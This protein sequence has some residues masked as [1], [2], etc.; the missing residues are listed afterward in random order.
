MNLNNT[1]TVTQQRIALIKP[2]SSQL[3]LHPP[4]QLTYSNTQNLAAASCSEASTRG[5]ISQL[6]APAPNRGVGREEYQGGGFPGEEPKCRDYVTCPGH[7]RS[8]CQS[9]ELPHPKPD[10]VSRPRPVHESALEDA[11]CFSPVCSREIQLVEERGA[12]IYL[13]TP[14]YS[15]EG[16]AAGGGGR[17]GGCAARARHP[18]TERGGERGFPWLPPMQIPPA[19]QRRRRPDSLPR[20]LGGSAPRPGL[21][22]AASPLTPASRPRSAPHPRTRSAPHRTARRGNGQRG[23]PAAAA[24]PGGG[25]ADNP[26][27][28]THPRRVGDGIYKN[29]KEKWLDCSGCKMLEVCKCN[30]PFVITV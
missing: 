3:F 14:S 17:A 23:H 24:A 1:A 16:L 27:A 9:P 26:P 11:A 25:S 28:T 6:A 15:P 10:L 29:T 20:P 4:S 18:G 30:S 22:G 8:S 21:P 12:V 13:R 5:Q 19:E 7:R 2:T